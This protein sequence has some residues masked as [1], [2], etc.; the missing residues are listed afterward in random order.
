MSR[1]RRDLRGTKL[2]QKKMS[3]ETRRT[4]DED[5]IASKFSFRYDAEAEADGDTKE[6]PKSH[7]GSSLL[8][9]P[10]PTILIPHIRKE[11]RQHTSQHTYGK[12]VIA[13]GRC[14]NQQTTR[15]KKIPTIPSIPT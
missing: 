10:N 12:G 13:Q 7:S 3:K 5:K 6:N 14:M 15:K 2:C 9:Y 4:I 8:L 11:E 1:R